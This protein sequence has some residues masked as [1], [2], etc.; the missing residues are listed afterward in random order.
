MKDLRSE[1]EALAS[2]Y[3]TCLDEFEASKA[4]AAIAAQDAAAHLAQAKEK[5]EAFVEAERTT[6]TG[7]IVQLC[8]AVEADVSLPQ[9]DDSTLLDRE[10]TL[11]AW[12]A[13]VPAWQSVHTFVQSTF[14]ELNVDGS[15]PGY[16]DVRWKRCLCYHCVHSQ[17][18]ME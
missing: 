1:L 17:F 12:S 13:R 9:M 14:P 7:T 10:T 18:D 3:D 6:A 16:L 8:E 11:A 2:R 15:S 5:A 4:A